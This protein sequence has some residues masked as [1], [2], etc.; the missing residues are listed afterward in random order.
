MEQL[1]GELLH[2]RE[3]D[4]TSLIFNTETGDVHVLNKSATL[5]IERCQRGGSIKAIVDPTK[6]A[7]RRTP[8]PSEERE[9]S[10]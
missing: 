6:H 1:H 5:I 3:A 2:R 4:G 9:S 10:V 8:K 7:T